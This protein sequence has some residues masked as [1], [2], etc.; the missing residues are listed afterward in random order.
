MPG[1]GERHST[2]D[3]CH[4]ESLGIRKGGIEPPGVPPYILQ[5]LPPKTKVCLFYGFV[6]S[7][8]TLLGMSPTTISL[9]LSKS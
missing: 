1:A 5:H 9:S 8:L 4:E 2:R 3:K 7:P 6:L